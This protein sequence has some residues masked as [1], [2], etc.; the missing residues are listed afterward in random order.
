[1]MERTVCG[2]CRSNQLKPFAKLDHRV[3]HQCQ[4]CAFVFASQFE[5]E[6]L[7][8]V[9]REEY[10]TSAN[11]PKIQVWIEQ[12]RLVW[13]GLVQDLQKTKPKIESLL[14]VGAGSGGFLQVFQA[15][16]PTTKLFAI[17]SS[18][19]AR[20]HL[21]TKIPLLTFPVLAAEHLRKSPCVFEVVT[22]LQCLE[23]VYD[24]QQL[25]KD[26]YHS[27]EPNGLLFITVPNRYSYKALI[28]GTREKNGYGNPSHL[29]F[30][31]NQT[32][33][34]MLE[35]AG[36]QNIQRIK[37]FGGTPTK[38]IFSIV[39]YGLRLLGISSELRWIAYK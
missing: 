20:H 25:C 36:F 27:L 26:I 2:L 31:S 21:Q 13:E 38:G 22:L 32:L 37:R 9:Y 30:F 19:E 11:D 24:P 4:V 12:N 14:D 33:K 39:Q 16:F 5:E 23:H 17:E 35:N 1:M 18:L 34:K 10:Y 3:L 28:Q 8:R 6:E 15:K 7:A 29:Q